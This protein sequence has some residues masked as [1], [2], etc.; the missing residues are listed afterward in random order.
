M[1]PIH[2]THLFLPAHDIMRS[3]IF[4]VSCTQSLPPFN[5][6]VVATYSSLLHVYYSVCDCFTCL[7]L[8]ARKEVT[9]MRETNNITTIRCCINYF[10]F[11]FKFFSKCEFVCIQTHKFILFLFFIS[12]ILNSVFIILFLKLRS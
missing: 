3:D 11:R 10:L 6:S 12:F 1:C 9:S 4:S 7:S 8:S 5:V 2:Q